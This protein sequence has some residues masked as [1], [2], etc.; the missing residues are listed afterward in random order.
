[1]HL[2]EVFREC[3]LSID[4]EK[5]RQAAGLLK[6]RTLAPSEASIL[7][8]DD[9]QAMLSFY[10]SALAEFNAVVLT[11]NNGRE[12]LDLIDQGCDFDLIISD[13]NM[14]VMDGIE[15]TRKLRD[16]ADLTPVIMITTESEHS[17]AD[18][19]RAA[20]V[21]GF[22]TKPFEAGDLR[23]LLSQHLHR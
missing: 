14:P 12:A 3:L 13:M 16:R 11:A 19:A 15:F 10:R 7:A 2:I 20:G 1:M 21:S 8:V 4:E 22:L 6:R 5:A 23:R 9:S 17:Q 18:L